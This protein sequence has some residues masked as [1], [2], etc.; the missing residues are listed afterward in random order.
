M[1]VRDI[2]QNAD[3]LLAM[4]PEQLGPR[5]LPLLREVARGN[6]GLINWATITAETCADYGG[7][8]PE[9]GLAVSAALT[10]LNAIGVRVAA[11]EQRHWGW[12]DYLLVRRV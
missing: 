3:V 11:P 10:F 7:R 9:C 5:L 12:F 8:G 2:V 4:Q 1:K 6:S